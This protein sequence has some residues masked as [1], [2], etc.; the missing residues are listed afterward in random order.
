MGLGTISAGID[1]W[2]FDVRTSRDFTVLMH[3][4]TDRHVRFMY[5][6][7]TGVLLSQQNEK[8]KLCKSS[9]LHL[10]QVFSVV[11]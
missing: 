7:L 4:V 11:H 10:L 9:D 2:L 6:V 3:A 8:N 5:L 1:T